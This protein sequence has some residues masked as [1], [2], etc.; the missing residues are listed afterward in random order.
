MATLYARLSSSP[1]DSPLSANT[2][3]MAIARPIRMLGA[4]CI[5]LCLFLVFQLHQS[6]SEEG[7]KLTHGMKKDP[8]V[9]RT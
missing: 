6:P 2:T 7:S 1:T 8:L 9:D 4:A 3:I 5:L